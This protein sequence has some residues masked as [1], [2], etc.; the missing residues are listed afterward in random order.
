MVYFKK[1][2]EDQNT[3]P[4]R[5]MKPWCCLEFFWWA[6]STMELLLL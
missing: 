5:S 1:L 2:G 3:S 6:Y 4:G